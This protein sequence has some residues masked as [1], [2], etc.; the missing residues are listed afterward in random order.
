[1]IKNVYGSSSKVHVFFVRFQRNLN[2]LYS[3]S[4][5]TRISDF[6]KVHPVGAELFHSEG[7]TERRTDMMKVVVAFRNFAN[8]PKNDTNGRVIWN[9]TH[10]VLWKY[11]YAL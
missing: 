1:M 9:E 10:T 4:K 3:F 6:M 5:N 7:L 2:F 11:Q 8:E